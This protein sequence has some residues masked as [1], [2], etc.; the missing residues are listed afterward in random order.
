ML[1]TV[2]GDVARE[3]SPNSD[4]RFNLALLTNT[5]MITL[6]FAT[7]SA[8]HHSKDLKDIQHIWVNLN[9]AE[10]REI[11]H[12]N[13]NIQTTNKMCKLIFIQPSYDKVVF[14]AL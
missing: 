8:T 5:I 6:P 11:K 9:I 12:K 14:M 3:H 7:F 13:V 2:R 4:F 1:V 10:S